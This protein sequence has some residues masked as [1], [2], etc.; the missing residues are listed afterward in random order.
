MKG[1]MGCEVEDSKRDHDW[2]LV[3]D[4]GK[5]LSRTCLSK[6]KK[7]TLFEKRVS[8]MARQLGLGTASNFVKFVDCTLTKEGALE[9]IRAASGT[10][11]AP[12]SKPAPPTKPASGNKPTSR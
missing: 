9:I 8:E 7:H 3:A 6:G 1:K 5:F 4:Q 11:L 2:Y 10:K 12:A